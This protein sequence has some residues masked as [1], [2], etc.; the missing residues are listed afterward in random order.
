MSINLEDFFISIDSAFPHM[1]SEWLLYEQRKKEATHFMNHRVTL[2]AYF[3]QNFNWN[4]QYEDC[5]PREIY[6]L[7]KMVSYHIVQDLV[8]SK[9]VKGTKLLQFYNKI[10]AYF[11]E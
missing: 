8:A 4:I 9:S 7:M 3:L 5:C 11:F 6:L 1:N 2:K 10:F